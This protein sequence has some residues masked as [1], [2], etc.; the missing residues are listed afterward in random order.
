MDCFTF[1]SLVCSLW[2]S[3]E[4]MSKLSPLHDKSTKCEQCMNQ[5]WTVM[6]VHNGAVVLCGS[7]C[8]VLN[9]EGWD[10]FI[11]KI[12][13]HFVTYCWTQ[14]NKTWN[15]YNFPFQSTQLTFYFSSDHSLRYNWIFLPFYGHYINCNMQSINTKKSFWINALC[16]VIILNIIGWIFNE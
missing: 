16:C 11:C 5:I 7:P 14:W 15:A 2:V 13:W 4:M 12:I 1:M 9:F 6:T 3:S 10:H 8:L